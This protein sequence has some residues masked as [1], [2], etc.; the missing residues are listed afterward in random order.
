MADDENLLPCADK[1]AFGTSKEAEVAAVVAA[2]QH[3]SQLKAYRCKYC[4]LWHL[5]SY[6]A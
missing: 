1:I 6:Y 2:H 3:G 4:D 5:S